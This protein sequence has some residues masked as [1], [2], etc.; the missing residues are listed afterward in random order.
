[1][2]DGLVDMFVVLEEE[3]Q[4]YCFDDV[5]LGDVFNYFCQCL[6]LMCIDLFCGL[7]QV[8]GWLQELVGLVDVVLVQ[9]LELLLFEDGVLY[10]LVLFVVECYVVYVLLVGI[11][12]DVGVD[13]D[14]LLFSLC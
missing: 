14:V 1:M 13:S 4:C 11:F 2:F 12:V 7:V 8:F 9:W 10:W 5:F 3:W 6:V